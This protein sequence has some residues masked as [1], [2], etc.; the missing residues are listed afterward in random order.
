MGWDCCTPGDAHS[1]SHVTYVVVDIA[2][3]SRQVR[4][5]KVGDVCPCVALTC[6]C[7][8]VNASIGTGC[9]GRVG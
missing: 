7:K 2:V 3:V 8:C 4:D 9:V 5:N 1:Y 6:T